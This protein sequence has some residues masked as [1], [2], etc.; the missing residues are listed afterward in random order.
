MLIKMIKNIISKV[1]FK[2]NGTENQEFVF[3]SNIEVPFSDPAVVEVDEAEEKFIDAVELANIDLGSKKD[4]SNIRK[5]NKVERYYVY[6]AVV[7]KD[8]LHLVNILLNTKKF[9]VRKKLVKR[10]F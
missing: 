6:T 9:R 8:K 1:K 3:E 2:F 4:I 7:D 5:L 10:L